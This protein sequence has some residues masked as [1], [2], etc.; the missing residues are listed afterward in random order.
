MINI[1]IAKMEKS[2]NELLSHYKD[3]GWSYETLIEKQKNFERRHDKSENGT[4][5]KNEPTEKGLQYIK[6]VR[7]LIAQPTLK[8]SNILQPKVDFEVAKMVCWQIIREK[9][10]RDGT[11]FSDEGSVKE[12]IPQLI[13]YFIGDANGEFSINKGIYL[14]GDTGSGKTFLME[15][16]QEMVQRLGLH[17]QS[18]KIHNTHNI[19]EQVMLT[20]NLDTSFYVSS[21]TAFDDFGTEEPIVRV[22]TNVIKPMTWII[23]RAYDK[24]KNSQQMTHFTS[25]LPPYELL[26]KESTGINQLERRVYE[27]ILEMTTSVKLTGKSKRNISREL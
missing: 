17:H 20:S 4:E 9:L 23:P 15:T 19:V 27:R 21:S 18:F 5:Y 6:K 16:M 24:F 1:K 14:W 3:I 12:V 8:Q 22:F 2:L 7:E 13:R 25:A 26:K 10:N 11:R